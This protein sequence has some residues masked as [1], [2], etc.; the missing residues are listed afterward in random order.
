[1]TSAMSLTYHLALQQADIPVEMH[2]YA[3]G[4]HAF[5]VRKTSEPITQWPTL[6]EKWMST[7]GVVPSTGG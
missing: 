5:G 3:K 7:I 6:A 1:M 2:L 4:G